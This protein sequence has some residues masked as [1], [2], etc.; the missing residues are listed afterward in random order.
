MTQARNDERLETSAGALRGIRVLDFGHY[1]P[2]PLLGMLL[3]DQG[4]D[5]IKV[6][7][8]G[9]DPARPESAFATWN[10]GK[11]SIVLDLKSDPGREHARQ[12]TRRADVLIE[13]FRPGVAERLGIG[14]EELAGLNPRLIYCSLPGF[15][16]GSPYRD[17]QGWEPIIGAATGLYSKVEMDTEPLFTPLPIASSFAAIVGAVAVTMALHDR[18]RC[19][20]GQRVEVPL[21]SAM[22]TAMGRHLVKFH[23]YKPAEQFT[24]PGTSW[25]AS[26]SAPMGGGCST[27]GCLSGL[28]GAF[29]K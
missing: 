22:F 7:R 10:R 18:G 21:H 24:S 29:W 4:A 8:P 19:G 9:G 5:V 11:R 25:P 2:G 6:E 27:T 14:Y 13:N 23:E 17:Q 15:G 26:T 28:P 20:L 3:A 16:E 12:L 1:I